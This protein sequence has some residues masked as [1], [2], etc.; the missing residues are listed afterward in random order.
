MANKSA[1]VA[2]SICEND[3]TFEPIEFGSNNCLY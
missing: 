3:L 2:K 1:D